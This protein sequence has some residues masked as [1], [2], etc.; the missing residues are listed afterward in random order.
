MQAA[1][2]NAKSKMLTSF[3]DDKQNFRPQFALRCRVQS[4][5]EFNNY[6]EYYLR[7]QHN[8]FDIGVQITFPIF[9]ASRR[10]KA[11]ESAADA[12]RALA[13][14][15]QTKLQTSEQV[16]SLRHSMNELA[17]QQRIAQLRSQLAQEQLEAIRTQLQNGSGSPN[18]PTGHAERRAAGAYPGARTVRGCTRCDL[19]DDSGGTDA[20]AVDWGALKTGCTR[21]LNALMNRVRWANELQYAM[22]PFPRRSGW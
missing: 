7:F 22:L 5:F 2:A 20:D 4:L 8:N 12:R 21:R 15:D 11:R 1:Y 10:A 16:Y 9:D 14:A 17:V 6:Q 3:G 19:L 18:G 13:E